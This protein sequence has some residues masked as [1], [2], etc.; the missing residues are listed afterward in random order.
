MPSIFSEWKNRFP[1]LDRNKLMWWAQHHRIMIIDQQDDPEKNFIDH[2]YGSELN[3]ACQ[4]IL[5]CYTRDLGFAKPRGFSVAPWKA[6]GI[7]V[8]KIRGIQTF[9]QIRALS[10]LR[11]RCVFHLWGREAG[12]LT[13]AVEPGRGHLIVRCD[14][15]QAHKNMRSFERAK[16]FTTTCDYLDCTKEIWRL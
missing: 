5:R 8:T 14:Y 1:P 2:K 10:L 15:P 4:S 16:P 7:H 11:E 6:R 12:H 9:Q 3:N 13:P